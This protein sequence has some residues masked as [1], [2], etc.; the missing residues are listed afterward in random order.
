MAFIKIPFAI[1]GQRQEIPDVAPSDNSVNYTTGY[2][3][4][5]SEDP[6]AGGIYVDRLAFNSIIYR[7]YQE[8]QNLQRG[9]ISKWTADV[10]QAIGGYQAGDICLVNYDIFTYKIVENHSPDNPFLAQIPVMSLKN[11]N[12]FSP[13]ENN[14]INDSWYI[15]D[16]CNF[17]E[18]K[19]FS[20]KLTDDPSGYISLALGEPQSYNFAQYPRVAKAFDGK[21]INDSIG[22]IYKYDELSFKLRD[23]RGYFPRQWSN[24]SVIDSNRVFDTLQGDAIRDFNIVATPEN[25]PTTNFS[26][27]GGGGDQGGMN[28]DRIYKIYNKVS[29]SIP[30]VPTT[31]SITG[32]NRPYN[33]NTSLAIKI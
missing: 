30:K 22:L 25:G 6:L 14:S 29:D 18:I 21:N 32:E 20:T 3:P 7:L 2:T 23:F 24:G 8:L 11:D 26:G 12:T 5:Y 4:P 33:F 19:M 17:G 31:D 10:A 1:K 28:R 16:G 13:Y 9:G 15:L 27:Y